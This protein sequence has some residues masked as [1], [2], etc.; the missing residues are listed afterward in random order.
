MS[1]S[2]HGDE[3]R[4]LWDPAD[5]SVHLNWNKYVEFRRAQ[6]ITS[7]LRQKA[8]NSSLFEARVQLLTPRVSLSYNRSHG[9]ADLVIMT[10]FLFRVY[11]NII[12]NLKRRYQQTSNSWVF[13]SKNNWITFILL[14]RISILYF[15]LVLYFN[16]KLKKQ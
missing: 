2:R 1:K 3:N 5:K 14:L 6:K 10:S 16:F 13:K 12:T 15:I 11:A 9:R 7:S 4:T 8:R